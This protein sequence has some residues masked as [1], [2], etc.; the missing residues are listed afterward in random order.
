MHWTTRANM[1]QEDY[2]RKVALAALAGYRVTESGGCWYVVA[3]DPRYG[4]NPVYKRTTQRSAWITAYDH[5][6]RALVTHE[7]GWLAE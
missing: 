4:G 3:P 2:D 6:Q 7:Q 1:E 5:L